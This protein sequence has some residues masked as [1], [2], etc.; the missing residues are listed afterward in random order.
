MEKGWRPGTAFELLPIIHMF[1]AA[2]TATTLL[3]GSLMICLLPR[4]ALT[5]EGKVNLLI[6]KNTLSADIEGASLEA[7]LTQIR[8]KTGLYYKTWFGG[9]QTLSE[10]VSVRFNRLSFK[11]GLERILSNVNHSLVLEGSSVAGVMLFGK[12]GQPDRT[13]RPSTRARPVNPQRR[14]RRY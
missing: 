13:R 1:N 6:D 4:F 11:E 14:T 7:V 12:P 2:K 3:I 9:N 5:Q 10:K 8:Q